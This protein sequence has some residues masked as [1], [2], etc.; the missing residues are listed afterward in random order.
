MEESV[1]EA[2]NLLKSHRD[3]RLTLIDPMDR[4]V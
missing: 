4:V 1:T 3:L 2:H